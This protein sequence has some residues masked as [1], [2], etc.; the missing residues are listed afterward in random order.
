MTATKARN[1]SKARTSTKAR[2]ARKAETI[3]QARAGAIKPD[4]SAT[5]KRATLATLKAERS[6]PDANSLVVGALVS[7]PTRATQH[8]RDIADQTGCGFASVSAM[9]TPVLLALRMMIAH[10]PKALTPAG[11][12]HFQ[13]GGLPAKVGAQ[14]E[15]QALALWGGRGAAS[16]TAKARALACLQ[17][18]APDLFGAPPAD[19]DLVWFGASGKDATG[20]IR[21][22]TARMV[23][24]CR[25]QRLLK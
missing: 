13:A 4:M 8:Y 20:R 1:V 7:D 24:A 9:G 18:V 23:D 17:Y 5:V 2:K 3:A 10:Y 19:D 14:R 6:A 15:A 25:A 12:K 11:V 16:D 21:T 22:V